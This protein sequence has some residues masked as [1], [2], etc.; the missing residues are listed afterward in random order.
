M[1]RAALFV[2]AGIGDA[3]LLLPLMKL[4]KNDN[5]VLTLIITTP[6]SCEEIFQ[7]SGF[8]E[9]ILILRGKANKLKNYLLIQ[10]KFDLVFLN[11]FAASVANFFLAAKLGEKIICNAGKKPFF[12]PDQRCV[13]K[14]AV[15]NV[16]DAFQ[17]L[18]LYKNAKELS[19]L[20]EEDFLLHLPA[21]RSGLKLPQKYI[22]LQLSA[23]NNQA[24]YKTW[25]I[26]QWKKFIDVILKKYNSLS[27]VLLGDSN[28][29][30]LEKE[31][32][33]NSQVISLMG[34]TS[35]RQVM[36]VLQQ[37]ICFIGHDGGLMHLSAALGT[38]SFTVWGGSDPELY[39]YSA[40]APAK[41]RV[42]RNRYPCQPCNSWINPNTTKTTDPLRCP[43]FSCL[44]QL[45]PEQVAEEFCKFMATLIQHDQ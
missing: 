28:E 2:S 44:T 32:E 24:P 8:H 15:L 26:G 14:Q 4:L 34:K 10:K 18:L 6:Y 31:W 23:G 43:D 39:A 16:H 12:M 41:H 9:E 20:K 29:Q 1:K 22:A 21:L 13:Q 45:K 7:K 19:P 17:N 36:E 42:V 40:I 27:V 3:V 38:P 37:A 35:I 11:I 30:Y 33:H 25:P 5:Y